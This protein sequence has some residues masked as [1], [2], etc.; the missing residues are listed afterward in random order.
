MTA[1]TGR[2]IA[3]GA[4]PLRGPEGWQWIGF[5]LTP[6]QTGWQKGHSARRQEQIPASPVQ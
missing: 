2:A 1:A 4:L 5:G 6:L 3:P